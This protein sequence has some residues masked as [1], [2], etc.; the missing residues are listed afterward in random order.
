MHK[1]RITF[2]KLINKPLF[3][4]AYLLWLKVKMVMVDI[5]SYYSVL[6]KYLSTGV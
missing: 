2:I 3:R 5:H 6:I 1:E 4:A